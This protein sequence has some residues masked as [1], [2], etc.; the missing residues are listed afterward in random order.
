MFVLSF[1]GIVE[2]INDISM[3]NM[4]GNLNCSQRFT[5][6][7]NGEIVHIIVNR[8]TYIVQRNVIEIGDEI[9]VYYDGNAPV[10]LIY[11]PQ[12]TAVLLAKKVPQYNVKVAYFDDNLVSDD[13]QLQIRVDDSVVIQYEN[14]QPYRGPIQ[15]HLLAVV[16]DRSTRSIPAQTTPISITVI[17]S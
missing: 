2:E 7:S 9:T 3:H 11:P 12:Y 10:P 13:H 16:Y 5:I 17:C 8:E 6:R 14:G 15:H 1:D 4:Q